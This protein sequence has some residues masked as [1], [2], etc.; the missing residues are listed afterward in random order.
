[1]TIN[2]LFLRKLLVAFLVGAAPPVIA[3]ISTVG[4][5]GGYHVTKAVLFAVASGAISAGVRAAF[6]LIPGITLVPSDAQP[7]VTKAPTVPAPKK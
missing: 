4:P 2:K 7:V 3:F 6:Q 5:T 1:M